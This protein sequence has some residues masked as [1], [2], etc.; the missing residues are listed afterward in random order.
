MWP[1]LSLAM[2]A[3]TQLPQDAKFG[4]SARSGIALKGGQSTPGS[5]M[6]AVT[7]VNSWFTEKDTTPDS[8]IRTDGSWTLGV[9]PISQLPA[10]AITS[11]GTVDKAQHRSYHSIMDFWL[12]T[13]EVVSSLY[14][15]DG[16]NLVAAKAK[17]KRALEEDARWNG[18]E[19][20]TSTTYEVQKIEEDE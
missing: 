12:R 8:G 19:Q 14:R 20:I 9:Q 18:I 7:F 6:A 16:R 13:T 5:Q 2:L 11:P 1:I 17:L 3:N 10:S 15:V 4:F